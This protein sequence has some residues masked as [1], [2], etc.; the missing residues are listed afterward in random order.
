MTTY[1]LPTCWLGVIFCSIFL[2]EYIFRISNEYKHRWW[3]VPLGVTSV[4]AIFLLLILSTYLTIC[5]VLSSA[6]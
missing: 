1:L 6:R 5:I 4:I 2:G 3:A